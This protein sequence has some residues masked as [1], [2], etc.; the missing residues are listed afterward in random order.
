MFECVN[1]NESYKYSSVF[2][3]SGKYINIKQFKLTEKCV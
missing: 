3:I 2:D 1:K